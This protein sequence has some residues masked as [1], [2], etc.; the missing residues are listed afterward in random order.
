MVVNSLG[1][2]NPEPE[3]IDA[4]IK[5]LDDDADWIRRDTIKTLIG[6]GANSEPALE[7]LRYLAENDFEGGGGPYPTI[8]EEALKAIEEIEK[9]IEENRVGVTES[10]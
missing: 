3:V 1:R 7:K 4:L 9:A 10:E 8:S 2:M 6:F 5:A